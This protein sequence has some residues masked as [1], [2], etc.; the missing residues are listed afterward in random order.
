MKFTDKNIEEIIES[1][2]PVLVD[3]GAQWCG[4]C[5]QIKPIIKELEAEYDGSVKIG[6]LDIEENNITTEKYGIRNIPT[7]LFF[8]DSQL[9]DKLVGA[10]TKDEINKILVNLIQ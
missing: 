1:G 6:I 8:K 5:K 9:V 4:P 7:L 10:K 3:F 2:Q